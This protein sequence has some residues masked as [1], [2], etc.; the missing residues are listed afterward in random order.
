MADY[1]YGAIYKRRVEITRQEVEIL[2]LNKKKDEIRQQRIELDRQDAA[3]DMKIAEAQRIVAEN[4]SALRD[5]GEE[6][7]ETPRTPTRRFFA[8]PE[9]QIADEQNDLANPLINDP[10]ANNEERDLAQG[11]NN[12]TLKGQSDQVRIRFE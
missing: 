2:A 10:T 9:A 6:P 1:R 7:A 8:F 5:M 11:F 4:L 3:C 12:I